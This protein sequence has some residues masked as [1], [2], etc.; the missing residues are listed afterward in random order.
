MSIKQI[1]KPASGGNY[2]PYYYK[3]FEKQT[4]QQKK[5]GVLVTPYRHMELKVKEWA[6][7]GGLPRKGAWRPYDGYAVLDVDG[8]SYWVG[9]DDEVLWRVEVDE[10][11]YHGQEKF[12]AKSIK[13]LSEVK[14]F[15][16]AALEDNKPKIDNRQVVARYQEEII[17]AIADMKSRLTFKFIKDKV[18]KAAK[19]ASDPGALMDVGFD[20]ANH[21]EDVGANIQGIVSDFEYDFEVIDAWEDDIDVLVQNEVDRRMGKAK[22]AS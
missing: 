16:K 4:E 22:K 20:I 7:V 18:R 17:K 8:I 9:D 10:A 6:P 2:H 19:G 1:G 14:G 11:G 3:W 15:M 21:I 13:P 5:D 12:V